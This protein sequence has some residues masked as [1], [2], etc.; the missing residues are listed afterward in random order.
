VLFR[1]QNFLVDPVYRALIL[2]VAQI[3]SADT[4]LEIGP[5]AGELTEILAEQA[6]RL[7]A[8]ELDERL[9]PL[10][11]QRFGG[12]PNVTIV[13]GDILDLDIGILMLRASK[14]AIGTEQAPR[15]CEY[16]VVANLPYYITGAALRRLM[17]AQ[18]PPTVS[19]LTLQREVAE[20]IVASPPNMSLLALGVQ[21]YC[22]ARLMES[23]PAR[24]FYPIPKVDSAIVRLER[25]PARTAPGV[26]PGAFFAAAR[27]GFSQPRKQLRN[28]LAGGMQIA[29]A[30]A[31]KALLS[32]Q[33]A[34]QRRAET[35]TLAEWGALAQTLGHLPGQSEG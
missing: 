17:E 13:Q 9:I 12:N 10:L 15:D 33:I 29:T 2:E 22:T 26:T 30:E 18:P 23:V 11:R 3:T 31:E 34:P 32:A 16:I 8:V 19:V 28:S 1:S 5:G 21:F 27:A 20:R 4:V 14:P 7:V 24:A 25:K 6:G 35:L